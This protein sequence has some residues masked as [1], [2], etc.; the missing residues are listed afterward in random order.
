MSHFKSYL[1]SWLDWAESGGQQFH[2][3]NNTEG[4][5]AN[6][7]EYVIT[8]LSLPY[9]VERTAIVEEI[10][11]NLEEGFEGNTVYPFGMAAYEQCK[12]MKS[13][14]KDPNRLAWVRKM[15]KEG[16]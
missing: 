1:Q 10:T 6:V 5:C 16:V 3:Y 14:H 8:V 4:L 12:M 15:L 13:M 2:P 7:Y 11:K 9:S